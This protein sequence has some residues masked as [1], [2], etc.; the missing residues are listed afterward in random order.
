MEIQVD[1]RT[2]AEKLEAGDITYQDYLVDVEKAIQ[3]EISKLYPV[4]S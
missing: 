4:E 1:N 3:K 2:A